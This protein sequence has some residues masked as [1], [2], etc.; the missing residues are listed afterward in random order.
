MVED[1]PRRLPSRQNLVNLPTGQEFIMP[2]GAP[3][4]IAFVRS[5]R[6]APC[7]L[8]KQNEPELQFLVHKV[9]YLVSVKE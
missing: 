7:I 4:L 1:Y 3:P 8:E 6:A 2:Q 9:D 5:F